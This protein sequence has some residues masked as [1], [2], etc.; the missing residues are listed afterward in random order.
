MTDEQQPDAESRNPYGHPPSDAS[1]VATNHSMKRRRKRLV[2]PLWVWIVAVLAAA[3]IVLVRVRDVS[4]DHAVVNILTL[5]L[6]FI[7]WCAFAFWFFFFSGYSGKVR[8]GCFVGLVASITLF[9][10]MFRVEQVSGEMVPKFS[11]RWA[12]PADSLL[13]TPTEMVAGD[14][15]DVTTTSEQD[16]PQFLGPH[17][18]GAIPNVRLAHDWDSKPPL[19]LWR[20][21]I[22]AGWS[23]FVAVNGYAFT[24]E[25]RGDE[26]LVTCYDITTGKLLWGH[27][28]A[29]RHSTVLGGVGPRSTPVVHD[30]KVYTLGPSG[31]V[32]CLEGATGEVVWRDNLLT[33]YNVPTGEDYLAVAWGRSNSP[34]IVDD[35]VVIPAGGPK[36]GPHVSLVAFNRLTG[37]LA[38]EAGNKQVSY[39][40][41]TLAMLGNQR[42]IVS[43]NEDNVTGHEPSDGRELWQIAWPGNSSANASVSQAS[44]LSD[45]RLLLSK[46]YGAGAALWK[47]TASEDGSIAVSES[48]SNAALLK[49]KFTN[50]VIHDGFVYG[51]SD[52]ILECVKLDSG[53]KQW[54]KGRYGHGQI[55]LAGDVLLIQAESGEVIM[56]DTNPDALEELA[57]FAA[58]DGKSWN[59]LCL[60]GD[61]LLV[62]NAE[63]AA[64][65]RLPMAD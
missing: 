7:G 25:Q 16:F 22:G 10:I 61:L 62:R 44:L 29:N 20:Q 50:H 52:G 8:L 59:N 28:E 14:G 49:T 5:I 3:M 31:S 46:G 41:P 43:V 24:M 55:L 48:W 63:E 65:Y 11:A 47:L 1:E 15:I 19:K 42:M 12:P 27:S 18:N 6:T 13:D 21:P 34:L 53:K 36:A 54:K 39:A 60:S 58:I 26:E 35:L 30:G 33:R 45:G 40:S 56:V 64:C 57:T 17:R 2:P 32:L 23:G 51:L 38:W 9:F 37:E 4:G